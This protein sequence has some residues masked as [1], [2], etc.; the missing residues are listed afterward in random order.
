[1]Q[2]KIPE[3]CAQRFVL[4][5]VVVVFAFFFIHSAISQ[6]GWRQT[7]KYTVYFDQTHAETLERIYAY[8]ACKREM[9]TNI[10]TR[11]GDR[12]INQYRHL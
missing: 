1:M 2:N 9:A 11:T 6:R 7:E 8:V 12:L 5:S 10:I 3:I 4:T